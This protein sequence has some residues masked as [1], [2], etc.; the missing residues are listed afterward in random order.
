[1]ATLYKRGTRYYLNWRQ[2]GRQVRISIGEIER[3][4]AEAVRAKKE[5]ELAGLIAPQSGVTV[6]GVIQEYLDWYETAR[7]A[8]YGRVKSALKPLTASLGG[9]MVDGISPRTFE[10]WAVGRPPATTEKAL[11]MARAAFRRAVSHRTIA[12]SP[13]DGAKFKANVL[14]RPP[15]YYRP[16]QLQRLY[17]TAHGHL[18][19]FMVATGIRRGEMA[20]ASAGDVRDG[21][22]VIE[23][24]AK[25]RTKSGKWRAVPLNSQATKALKK[26]GKG[27]LV[28]VHPDTLSDWF[29]KDAKAAGLPGSLH[30]LRHTFCTALVQA[31]VSL[32]EVMKLAG[33]S[34][35]KVTERYAHHAPGFGAAAVGTMAKWMRQGLAP[36]H[37]KKHT[38]REKT[39]RPRSSA[40]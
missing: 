27:L 38:G 35:I 26:L 8:T 32:Y 20:K 40:G 33:H 39:R 10:A 16:E 29:A 1:V 6:D 11:K 23:S 30:W 25:G 4:E 19:A 21:L 28:D 15:D 5:A 2:D 18:W 37:K 3:K 13:M 24:T 17:K 36:K 9:Q 12:Q 22:L 34:S 14:S 7:P 31:G